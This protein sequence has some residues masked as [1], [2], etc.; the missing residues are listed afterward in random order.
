MVGPSDARLPR[1]KHSPH[2]THP[3]G[4]AARTAAHAQPAAEASRAAF[5][6]RATA[7]PDR[8]AIAVGVA[9]YPEQWP[10]ERW[11]V[12]LKMMR[13]TGFNTVR[14]GEFAWSRMEP[15]EGKFDFAWMDRAIAAAQRHGF[16]VV[17]GTPT[18]APP[19]WL[20]QAYPDTLRI[21]EKGERAGH[22]ALPAHVIREHREAEHR[23]Q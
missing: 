19:A 16:M 6:Q 3:G 9:W 14:I 1:S 23:N 8:P 18:A 20:T 13:D 11:D 22:G 10:E 2:E 7:Y 17:I 21:D 12:D 15:V 5:P 4:D